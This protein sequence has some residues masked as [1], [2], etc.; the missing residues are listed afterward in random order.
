M[1]G[2]GALGAGGRA[3]AAHRRAE[4]HHRLGQPLFNTMA[5]FTALF[6]ISWFQSPGREGHTSERARALRVPRH[7]QYG[8]RYSQQPVGLQDIW[9]SFADPLCYTTTMPNNGVMI[10][11]ADVRRGAGS[12][13]GRRRTT[14][15]AWRSGGPGR[16]AGGT[17][18]A[19]RSRPPQP[20]ALRTAPD[21]YGL[22]Q[23]RIHSTWMWR[24]PLA[25][26]SITCNTRPGALTQ[27]ED[28][29]PAVYSPMPGMP[30][31][32]A[33]DRGRA[34]PSEDTTNRAPWPGEHP[35]NQ[36]VPNQTLAFKM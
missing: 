33:E 23:Q 16:P 5:L 8:R 26:G 31:S 12:E 25:V 3:G 36:N 35:S 4:L 13:G 10:R 28:M 29:A 32:S 30:R 14:G 15:G 22:S 17:Q 6:D 18:P 11:A 34:P 24:I 9:P 21:K 2:E 1:P 7:G 27:M 19:T 20:R